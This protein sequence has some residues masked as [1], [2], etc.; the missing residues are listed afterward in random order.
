[1]KIV[2]AGSGAMGLRFGW[3]LKHSGND[4]T[5]IDGWDKNIAAIR[6]DGVTAEIN[7]KKASEKMPILALEEVAGQTEKADLVVVF[8][9]SMGLEKMLSTIQPVIGENTY[10]LCLLNGLGHVEVLEKYVKKDHII[11]GVTMVSTSMPGPG[12]VR[13]DGNGQTELQCLDAS[14]TDET[15]KVVDVFNKAGMDAVYSENVVYSIWRKACVNGVVNSICALLECSMQEFGKTSGADFLT[16]KIIDEFADVAE[17]EGVFLDRKEVIDH[18]EK[19]FALDHYP[20]MYQDLVANH[21]PTEIDYINGAVWQ[22]GVKYS[23]ATP[24]CETITRL[25]HTKEEAMGVK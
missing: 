13:F 5:L 6:K 15:K 25:I 14:G 21:R 4:V 16:R 10:I 8:T 18:V 22:K 11:M 9:K 2:I 20:S 19:S 12:Q 24:Y 1:M 23:V 3:Q 7:G 17:R